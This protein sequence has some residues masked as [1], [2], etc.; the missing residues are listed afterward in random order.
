M[1]DLYWNVD[2][3]WNKIIQLWY[4]TPLECERCGC[5]YKE[6]S[7]IGTWH[8]K[9]HVL[10][11]NSYEQKW[12]CCNNV[13]KSLMPG[14]SNGCIKADHRPFS[15]ASYTEYNDIPIPKNLVPHL[16]IT[17]ESIVNRDN[18]RESN[19]YYTQ[20]DNVTSI[21]I[22]RFDWKKS[23]QV[24]TLGDTVLSTIEKGNRKG[25]CYYAH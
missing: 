23:D 3:Q 8:C 22:R 7:N 2:P 6:I 4:T 16:G 12:P 14:S 21:I 1:S 19:K 13:Q 24:T 17:N 5:K 10:S 11:W 20:R 9:Q 25:L 15:T 18:I